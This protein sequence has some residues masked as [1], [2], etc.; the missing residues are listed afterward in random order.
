MRRDQKNIVIAGLLLVN[1]LIFQGIKPALAC[2]SK[3][4]HPTLEASPLVGFPRETASAKPLDRASL[5]P[6]E[7]L[8]LLK[9]EVGIMRQS[10]DDFAAFI[11]N[12]GLQSQEV[13]DHYKDYLSFNQFKGPVNGRNDLAI[14]HFIL[15][16]RLVDK[17]F[18]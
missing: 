18:L 9:E 13:A 17:D 16:E 6:N 4:I 1:I 15:S 8:A 10:M 14:Y 7:R 11:I 3:E 12:P 2:L 5:T